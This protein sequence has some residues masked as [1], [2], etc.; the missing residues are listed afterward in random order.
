MTK[1]P[2]RIGW[3]LLLI[4]PDIRLVVTSAGRYSRL[5]CYL[6]RLLGFPIRVQT[7][8]GP[9]FRI[10]HYPFTIIRCKP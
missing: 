4:G 9:V 8:D 3:R 1:P 6:Q 10:F 5:D 2:T 7:E